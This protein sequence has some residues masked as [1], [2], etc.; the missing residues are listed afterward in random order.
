M[1]IVKPEST[2]TIG[3]GV[4]VLPSTIKNAGNGLFALRFFRKN[5]FITLYDGEHMTRKEA[6]ARESLTHMA[7][8]EGIIVDGLK[9]PVQGRGGGSFANG[10][11]TRKQSNAEIV[12]NL[13]HVCTRNHLHKREYNCQLWQTRFFDCLWK[14]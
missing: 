3:N 1:R 9:V 5:E 10:C 14:N 4:N 8:R 7:S 13:G 6:W 11:V 12:A 2:C